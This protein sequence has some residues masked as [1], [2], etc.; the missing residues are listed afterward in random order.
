MTFSP[1]ALFGP[2]A[3]GSRRTWVWATPFVVVLFMLGGQIL[4]LLPVKLLG[5]ISRENIETYPHILF[6]IIGAFG[7][8]ALLTWAWIRGFEKR[9]LASVGLTS[10][11]NRN[12]DYR[13]GFIIGLVMAAAV[14][15]GVRVMGGYVVESEP[16]L[17]F[18]AL[19]PIVVLLFA[20]V[21][22]A[23][24]EE[25][26]FRGWM[27]SRISERYGL[28]AG[29][30][31]NSIL[32]TL[33]HVDAEHLAEIGAAGIAIFV[34]GIML[35]G[36]FL[37]LLVIRDRSIWSAA[38]W[39]ASWNWMFITWFGLPTTGIELGLTPLV[40]DYMPAEGAA[41]W[42]TGGT[43]GP[44][45]SFLTPVVLAIGCI[46]VWLMRPARDSAQ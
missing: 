30:V 24:T 4:F 46:A 25:F 29:V 8:S 23:G 9:S 6:L 18:N 39:H 22:Q 44:E 33:M 1:Y 31:G 5:L 2:A 14:V 11:A 27:L 34:S 41:I 17:T 13:Q 19:V 43:D 36:I 37:S 10:D 3:D 12:R 7:M 20:F 15:Y 16:G 40:A 26:V 21:L 35:F 32:F 42:L 28:V 45:G 38:A